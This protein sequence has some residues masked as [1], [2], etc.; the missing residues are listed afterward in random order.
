MKTHSCATVMAQFGRDDVC[1]GF[2]IILG[3]I[4]SAMG[5]ELQQHNSELQM[6]GWSKT[7]YRVV[8]VD[9][10]VVTYSVKV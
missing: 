4:V 10:R 5:I 7:S 1:R 2:I 3:R 6:I 8:P 9:M